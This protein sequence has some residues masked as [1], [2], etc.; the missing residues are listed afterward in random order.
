M[1]LRGLDALHEA[2]CQR[3]IIIIA[4][5]TFYILNIGYKVCVCIHIYIYIYVYVQQ[6]CNSWCHLHGVQ[7]RGPDALH[8]APC[9]FLV[10]AGKRETDAHIRCLRA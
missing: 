6:S 1:Q 4:C 10:E 7:L 5:F 9:Q 3:F 2:P 8:E